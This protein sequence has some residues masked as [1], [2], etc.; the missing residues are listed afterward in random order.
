MNNTG[1]DS[2][3]SL[4]E[5]PPLPTQRRVPARIIILGLIAVVFAIVI[6][7]QVIGVLYAIFFPPAAPVPDQVTLVS[8]T[9]KDYGVD[10]WLYSSD[11]ISA[12]GVLRYYLANNGDCQIAP[13]SCNTDLSIA[14]AESS[15][16]SQNVARCSGT[17]NFSIFALRW[18]VNI[19]TGSAPGQ[20]SQFRL[21]REIFWT[22]AVP[23]YNPPSLNAGF[24]NFPTDEPT[25]SS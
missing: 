10:D 13:L 8:H 24:S 22:G 20:L 2:S 11:K 12:C 6:G 21:N 17:Q 9:S 16:N 7:S 5:M 1:S 15:T 18:D 23:P 19:A 14:P 3:E 4:K 25:K